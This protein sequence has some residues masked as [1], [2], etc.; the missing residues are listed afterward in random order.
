MGQTIKK[1]ELTDQ[2][3][4]LFSRVKQL[5]NSSKKIYGNIEI[6]GNTGLFIFRNSDGVPTISM[7]GET[8]LIKTTNG[9]VDV[10]V[11]TNAELTFLSEYRQIRESTI[12]TSGGNTFTNVAP[13]VSIPDFLTNI[14]FDDWID[15]EWYFEATLS[16]GPGTAYVRLYN[17]TDGVAVPGSVITHT[18]SSYVSKRVGPL[19]KYTGTK[20][21]VVQY[22]HS[23]S[24]GGTDYVNLTIARHIF[25][26]Q[27]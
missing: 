16:S 17:N 22:G 5:E 6:D 20:E 21:L 7:D 12:H 11:A 14:N 10:L 4:E 1:Q 24:G 9:D 8:G 26:R 15:Q 27:Q 18:T 3:A 25:R 13:Y 23:P 2:I 19:T